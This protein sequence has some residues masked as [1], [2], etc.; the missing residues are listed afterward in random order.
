MPKIWMCERSSLKT[1]LEAIRRFDSGIEAGETLTER[2]LAETSKSLSV[3]VGRTAVIKV[4]GI[5]SENG[6]SLWDFFCG[7]G[8]TSYRRIREEIA[9]ANG[10]S[11]VDDILIVFD[12]PGGDV[13]GVDETYKAIKD[14][15]KPVHGV[16]AG[17]CASAGYYLAS[18]CET[19]TAKS[20]ASWIGSIGVVVTDVEDK[21][22]FERYGIYIVELTSDNAGNKRLSPLSKE[23]KEELLKTA[24]AYE[25]I[26]HKRVTEG[27]GITREKIIKDFGKGSMFVA[28]DPD[29]KEKDALSRGMI[30][31]V[32]N[33][34]QNSEAQENREAKMTLAEFLKENSIAQKEIDEMV[35]AAVDAA[36]KAEHE[37]NSR[38][39]KLVTGNNY[40]ETVSKLFAKVVSGE[41]S[42]ESLETVIASLDAHAEQQRI[43]GAID[44]QEETGAVSSG[45]GKPAVNGGKDE[46]GM[47]N[48]EADIE[49][50]ADAL[51]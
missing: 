13:N 36:V 16:V 19:I 24:N 48:N 32:K 41:S 44:E 15:E 7:S 14:S 8:G 9:A 33:G 47:V 2:F 17:M 46:A 34:F 25:R 45:K 30:D 40:G 21:E 5:L 3:R 28:L 22:F 11:A 20:P 49:A 23:G 4:S 31:D 6:P 12:T 29:S 42:I 10:D 27:R 35:K 1:Y 39:A 37:K 18:A 50:A 43:A 38:A 26:F 51:Y